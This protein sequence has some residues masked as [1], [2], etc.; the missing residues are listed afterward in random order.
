MAVALAPA[1]GGGAAAFD[2]VGLASGAAAGDWGRRW[3]ALGSDGLDGWPLRLRG[4]TSESGLAVADV[5]VDGDGRGARLLRRLL[6]AA[7][8][9]AMRVE[10]QVAVVCVSAAPEPRAQEALAGLRGFRA[11]GRAPADGHAL[12]LV[13]P[14]GLGEWLAL[15]GR[16]TPP[17]AADDRPLSAAARLSAGQGVEFFLSLPAGTLRRA[18]GGAK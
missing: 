18:L 2:L 17:P 14:R 16:Q 15:G 4:A 10:K 8:K 9:A 6:G 11:T 13:T 3:D 1:Q 5:V 7:P 12:L